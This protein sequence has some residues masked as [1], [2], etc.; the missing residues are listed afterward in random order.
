VLAVIRRAASCV[1]LLSIVFIACSSSDDESVSPYPVGQAMVFG[2]DG[3]GVSMSVDA[4]CESPVCQS[5]IERCGSDA[6]ADVVLDRSGDV[7][8]VMCYSGGLAV[9]ELERS[10][11]EGLGISAD[12]VYVFDSLDDGGD[13]IGPVTVTEPNVILYGGGA[14]LSQIWGVLRV[15]APGTLVRGISIRD[16]VTIDRN[17][18]KLSLVEIGGELTINGNGVTIS[19][20]IVHGAIHLVGSNTVLVRNLLSGAAELSGQNL[21]CNLNQ[22]FDDRDADGAIDDAELGGEVMCR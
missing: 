7:A 5:V 6:F 9:S 15:D 11:L 2:P 18:V 3:G 8:D 20:S 13:V 21:V 14:A 1:A 16:D 10:P 19:E 4:G 12:T 17:D 22:R